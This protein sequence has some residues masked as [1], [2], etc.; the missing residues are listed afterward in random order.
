MTEKLSTMRLPPTSHAS[1]ASSGQTAT[2][3]P[4]RASRR[5]KSLGPDNASLESINE[6]SEL[7][8]APSLDNSYTPPPSTAALTDSCD[9][10]PEGTVT[11][12]LPQTEQSS[13]SSPTFLPACPSTPNP[14]GQSSYTTADSDPSPLM[15]SSVTVDTALAVTDSS[16]PSPQMQSSVEAASSV[17]SAKHNDAPS[18]S[19]DDGL[20]VDD[21]SGHPKTTQLLKK[22]ARRARTNRRVII[23]HPFSLRTVQKQLRRLRHKVCSVVDGSS[24]TPDNVSS[25]ENTKQQVKN[26]LKL[27]IKVQIDKLKERVIQLE[28]T[29]NTLNKVN[30]D[31]RSQVGDLK[32]SL[33]SK[34]NIQASTVLF[35]L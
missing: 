25:I 32:K 8:L 26:E 17:E 35:G 13:T 28:T 33:T 30:S 27:H 19:D 9:I 1:N 3:K 4:A 11:P 2:T 7:A 16:V 14:S 22:K 5:L 18:P 21:G 6:D 31:L 20:I 24:K 29:V 23:R 12:V 10:S 34:A 15:Q